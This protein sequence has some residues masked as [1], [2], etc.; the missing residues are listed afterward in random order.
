MG[1]LILCSGKPA[2]HPL[3]IEELDI[4]LYTGEELSYYIYN[5]LVLI[6]GEDFIN[7]RLYR[8]I[9]DDLGNTALATK[10]QRWARHSS[11]G[12]LLMV[13]LQDLHYY[14]N[15]E[16][17]RFQERVTKVANLSAR[18]RVRQKADNLFE[19]RR[20]Y[21]AIAL[22]DR[23]LPE[24]GQ[25]LKDRDFTGRIWHNRASALCGLFSF[26]QAVDSYVE[27]YQLLGDEEI[28]RKI[29]LIGQLEPGV[30]LPKDLIDR[31][32]ELTLEKWQ[33]EID[34]IFSTLTNEGRFGEA[35]IL[36]EKDKYRRVAGFQDLITRWKKEY[37]RSQ[38]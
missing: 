32:P 20:F 28:L 36:R 27:A 10:L 7:E 16:L 17:S 18:E 33:D 30:K 3:Y 31:V 35:A 19:K 12:E 26:E 22:Y 8:F 38:G 37:R 25:D 29:F 24:N 23:L 13:I 4:N 11:Q 6:M 15:E 1:Q 9:A 5:N 2:A 21:E 34:G 14:R